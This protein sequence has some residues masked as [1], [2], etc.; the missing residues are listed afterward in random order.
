MRPPLYYVLDENHE[1]RGT[2]DVREWSV[3]FENIEHRRVACTEL[4]ADVSVSTV[5]IGIDHR[6]VGEGDPLLFETLVFGGPLDGEM[7]RYTSWG[8]AERGHAEIVA[9]V[10]AALRGGAA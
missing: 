7:D 9:R 1:P 8:G 2:K 4:T 6:F 5:F 10:M 3:F